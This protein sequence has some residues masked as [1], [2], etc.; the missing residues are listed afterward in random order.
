MNFKFVAT[1]LYGLENILK[2]EIEAAGAENS[3]L[4]NRAVEF[5]GSLALMYKLNL[6]LRTALRILM[7]VKSFIVNNEDQLYH[8]V[9]K[10]E[11]ETWF[12]GH[13]SFAVTPVVNSP[14]FRHSRYIAQ[15]VKDA[16]ADRFRKATG[17]RP[18][19][20]L[21]NPDVIVNIHIDDRKADISLD[22]SG[23]PLFKRGYRTATHQAALNEVLAAGLIKLAG[24]DYKNNCLYDPMCGSGT[25]AIEAAMMA[26]NIFPGS[27]GRSYAFFNWKHFDENLF[28]AV[29]NRLPSP[30]DMKYPV[31]A[32]DISA[33]ALIKA[34]AN[35]GNA[36]L[37]DKIKLS[38]IDFQA[39][40]SPEKRGVIIMNPPYGE[41]L[42]DQNTNQLYKQIGDT[43]KN[44][45][46]GFEA[47]IIS[48]NADAM[49][50]IGLHPEKKIQLMNGELKC[51]YQKFTIFEGSRKSRYKTDYK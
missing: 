25:I 26:S 22:S 47:W 36:G 21:K 14:G 33:D 34:K 2:D 49:K 42:S 29:K 28:V 15:K 30:N 38:K 41:R 37:Q 31:Y 16:I 4:L 1:T 51:R 17:N 48:P 40:S 6:S 19:V 45:Y 18:S 46:T 13:H 27:F 44:K 43:L 23:T 32:S 8:E 39:S 12:D 10:I 20:N 3:R 50:C 9:L 7:H 35:I 5:S 11:W 24:W